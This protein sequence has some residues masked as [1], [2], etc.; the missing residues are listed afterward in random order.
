MT[1]A[2]TAV[3]VKPAMPASSAAPRIFS[4]AM[5]GSLAAISGLLTLP[6]LIVLATGLQ[7]A[8]GL[9]RTPRVLAFVAA[10][11]V[12]MALL[13]WPLIPVLLVLAPLSVLAAWTRRA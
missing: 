1:S 7:M 10:T 13:R 4:Q 12:A 9:P 11:F 6:L 5:R 2:A 3:N 8:S